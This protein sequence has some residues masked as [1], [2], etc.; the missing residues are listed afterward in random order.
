MPSLMMRFS[1]AF[2]VIMPSSRRMYSL[3]FGGSVAAAESMP[4]PLSSATFART[5][6]TRLA[7][8][9]WERK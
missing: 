6:R 2:A 7:G 5:S 9:G 3:R 8:S 1:V 4:V